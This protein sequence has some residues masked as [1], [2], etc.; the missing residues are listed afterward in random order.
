MQ[1]TLDVCWAFLFYFCSFPVFQTVLHPCPPQINVSANDQRFR[2]HICWW[3]RVWSWQCWQ[4]GL[5]LSGQSATGNTRPRKQK[6]L[7]KHRCRCS[8]IGS[9]SSQM[10]DVLPSMLFYSKVAG[11]KS[12]CSCRVL[13]FGWFSFRQ[14]ETVVVHLQRNERMASFCSAYC[15]KSEGQWCLLSPLCVCGSQVMPAVTLKSQF[16]HGKHMVREQIY[17]GKYYLEIAPN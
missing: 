1:S 7:K 13:S 17:T 14:N 9:T 10:V 8:W 3:C 4:V 5:S 6:R 16:Q 15:W 2:C 11:K 12:T